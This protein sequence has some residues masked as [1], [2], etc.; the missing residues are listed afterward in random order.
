MALFALRA[1]RIAGN[2]TKLVTVMGLLGVKPAETG[3]MVSELAAVPAL[4][5]SRST[6]KEVW[7]AF[8]GGLYVGRVLGTKRRPWEASTAF[9]KDRS[10]CVCLP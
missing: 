3:I 5:L 8:Y 7:T 10:P 6:G 2:S 4:N 9:A 1:G